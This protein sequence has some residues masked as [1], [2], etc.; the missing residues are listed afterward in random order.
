MKFK[1]Y[2]AEKNISINELSKMTGIPYATLYSGIEN[3]DSMKSDNLKKI[4][5]QLSLTMDEVFN[6]L[7]DNDKS[8]LLSVFRE[9]KNLKMKGSIYHDT[10]I[11]FAYNTNRI[12]GSKLSEEETRYI[13]ETNTIINDK[14]S[15]N[16]NDIVEVANHFYVFDIM[17][18]TANEVLSERLI[19]EYHRILK[20]G[21]VDSRTP[22]F[23]VGDYKKHPNE[24]GGQSTTPPKEV[25]G[26]IKKL[27]SWYNQLETADFND[28]IE[29]H[30]KFESIHPFQDGNGR[31]GRLIM[32]KECLKH[33]IVPFIIE[34]EY[35][36]YYYRG[37]SKYKEDKAFLTDT[38]LTM[39]DKYKAMIV[40]FLPDIA[41]K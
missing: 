37:L 27:L 28:I 13:F 9:Q 34:D 30:Y 29:F 11:K 14:P 21:T 22:W 35:K 6:M 7:T 41:L 23:N 20:N 10:Q 15:N 8:S 3:P 33:N 24:V 4:A 26:Q 17:L 25:A 2:L 39:Q 1:G 18:N 5:E 12:E 32:F 36:A 19:K 31:I 38:C 40:S 16:I